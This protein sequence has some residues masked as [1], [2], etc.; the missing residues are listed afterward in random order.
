MLTQESMP[1]EPLHYGESLETNAWRTKYKELVLLVP[2]LRHSEMSAWAVAVP[3]L[4]PR[5][6]SPHPSLGHSELGA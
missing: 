5:M 2:Y 6:L 4:F 1:Y 3:L